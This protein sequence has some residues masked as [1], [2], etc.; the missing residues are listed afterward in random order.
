VSPE[1]AEIGMIVLLGLATYALRVGGYLV[2]ARFE[3]LDPRLEAALE[4]VPASVI[5]ALVAPVAFATGIAESIAALATVLAALRWPIM[6]TLLV[7]AL[8]VSLLRAAGL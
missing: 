8:S 6:P 5:T 7:A 2:L 3:R 4:A 1:L